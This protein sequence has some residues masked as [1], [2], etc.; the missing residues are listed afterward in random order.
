[1][2]KYIV[3]PY[4]N[5]FIKTNSAYGKQIILNYC[6]K[7]QSGG[8]FGKMLIPYII[9]TLS[10]RVKKKKLEIKMF[11]KTFIVG[12]GSIINTISRTST[13]KKNIGNAIPIRVNRNAGLRRVWNFQKP[14]I[15]KLTALGLEH[16]QGSIFV[17]NMGE[18]IND[19][20][21]KT[22]TMNDIYSSGNGETINGVLYPV[23]ENIE[24]F[25]KREEG[26]FRLRL[27]ID[28]IE[29][30]SWQKLPDYDCKIYIYCLNKQNQS[31]RPTCDLPILQTYVDIIINGCLEYG[32]IFAKEFIKTTYGW[33]KWWLND[34]TIARRPW[35]NQPN[36]KIIN[37]LLKK[38]VNKDNC[39]S[40][41]PENYKT[42]SQRETRA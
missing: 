39:C 36:F 1:M 18:E 40:T 23:Y 32:E 26:Y 15:A 37:K 13:G 34:R 29:S 4:T 10:N 41:L 22:Y 27:K 30:L 3:D 35:I 7:Q 38:Y 21:F 5:K 20:Y 19:E 11:P 42:Y 14:N 12:Y 31:Q 28:Q 9:S 16:T 2:Y 33:S 25:D 17:D 6:N 8:K 24:E